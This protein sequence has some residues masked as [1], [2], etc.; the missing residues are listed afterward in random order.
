V[1]ALDGVIDLS[2]ED[3]ESMMEET[4]GPEIQQVGIPILS[5]QIREVFEEKGLTKF[6]EM[7]ESLSKGVPEIPFREFGKMIIQIPL[8]ANF[9]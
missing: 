7:W 2:K 1:Y 5:N 6:A 4:F 3:L 9:L 8:S